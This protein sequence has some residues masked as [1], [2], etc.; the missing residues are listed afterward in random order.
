MNTNERQCMLIAVRCSALWTKT[1]DFEAPSGFNVTDLGQFFI[2]QWLRGPRERSHKLRIGSL[3]SVETVTQG[4]IQKRACTIPGER[5]GVRMEIDSVP[6]IA[7]WH[8]AFPK[9]TLEKTRMN[10]N[11]WEA[12]K[13][14]LFAVVLSP[15]T[16]NGHE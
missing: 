1:P 7:C 12:S 13:C 5:P 14:A 16:A 9:L 3:I 6:V 2:G 10:P 4:A 11:L 15:E 8:V